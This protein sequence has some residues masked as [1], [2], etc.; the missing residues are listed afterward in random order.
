MIKL[1]PEFQSCG[2]QVVLPTRS[3]TTCGPLPRD[4]VEDKGAEG[5]KADG[6]DYEISQEEIASSCDQI[7]KIVGYLVRRPNLLLIR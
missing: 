1:L 3:P 6:A 2:E 7:A 5:Q 4:E